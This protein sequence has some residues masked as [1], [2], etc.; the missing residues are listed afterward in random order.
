MVEFKPNFILVVKYIF[1]GEKAQK[2]MRSFI[3]KIDLRPKGMYMKVIREQVL[4]II[5]VVRKVI[6]SDKFKIGTM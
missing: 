5:S 1:D 2:P 4:E 6:K 3:N